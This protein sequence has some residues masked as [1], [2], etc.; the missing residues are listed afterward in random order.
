MAPHANNPERRRPTVHP[1]VAVWAPLKLPTALETICQPVLP[2]PDNL[3]GMLRPL[4]PAPAETD[5]VRAWSGATVPVV[6][7]LVP[8]YNHRAWIEDC[9]NGILGQVT[10]FPFEVIIRDDAS[11]DDT[12]SVLRSYAERYPTI[13]RL[14]LNEANRFAVEKGIPEMIPLARGDIIAICEGDDYWCRSDKLERQVVALLEDPAISC[15]SHPVAIHPSGDRYG[16]ELGGLVR[17][18]RGD[19]SCVRHMPTM[20]LAFRRSCSIP[21]REFNQAPFPDVVLKSSLGS[22]GDVVYDSTYLGAVYR[23]HGKGLYSGLTPQESILKSVLSRLIA[24]QA[25]A[26]QGMMSESEAMVLMSVSDLTYFFDQTYKMQSAR[27]L[28]RALRETWDWLDGQEL[29]P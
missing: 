28:Y 24:A 22:Q 14:M 15:V 18:H 16:P 2:R 12:Q 11:T 27:A 7:V 10:S 8:V 3:G 25:L 19:M 20:S 4:P 1:W 6:S 29:A 23:M 13:V 9:L 21:V 5:V 26:S 17:F